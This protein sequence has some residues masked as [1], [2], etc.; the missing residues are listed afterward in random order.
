M[1]DRKCKLKFNLAQLQW[2]NERWICHFII[3]IAI[4]FSGCRLS[5]FVFSIILIV[6]VVASLSFHRALPFFFALCSF[7]FFYSWIQTFSC[8]RQEWL[9]QWVFRNRFLSHL[10][11][12]CEPVTKVKLGFTAMHYAFWFALLI[13]VLAI[14]GLPFCLLRYLNVPCQAY[15]WFTMFVSVIMSS[16]GMPSSPTRAIPPLSLGTRLSASCSV[17]SSSATKSSKWRGGK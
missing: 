15:D 4:A 16:A 5:A 9:C 17:M 13:S 7:A 1:N 14:F 11:A 2:V 6:F 3:P 12:K 10:S 8:V